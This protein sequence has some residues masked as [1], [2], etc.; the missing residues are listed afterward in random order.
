MAGRI[1]WPAASPAGREAADEPIPGMPPACASFA[2]MAGPRTAGPCASRAAST[3]VRPSGHARSSA[4]PQAFVSG[5]RHPRTARS[6]AVPA[7]PTGTG[8]RV[9]S[10]RPDGRPTVS[11]KPNAAPAATAR[12]PGSPQAGQPRGR[13]ETIRIASCSR[14]LRQV[15]DAHLRRRGPVRGLRSCQVRAAG[16]RGGIRSAATPLC[17]PARQGP[18]AC[19]R[20]ALPG[21]GALRALRAQAR[22]EI[23]DLPRHPDLEPDLDSSRAGE[24]ARA[25]AVQQ[26][27]RRRAL[28]GLRAARARRGRERSEDESQPFGRRQ[29]LA[30][31]RVDQSCRSTGRSAA[32]RG[33]A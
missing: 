30:P 8:A 27:G 10:P 5:A 11:A 21:G 3:G 22:R 24:R 18:I 23:G 28:S 1:R 15:P 33:I 16:R 19:M 31:N 25:R 26:R 4:G 6:S 29:S 2:N 9:P 13:E 14:R 20:S 17:R 32:R 12:H 7:P